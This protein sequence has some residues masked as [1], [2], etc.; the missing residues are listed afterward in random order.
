MKNLNV[1]EC[2]ANV[3]QIR[4]AYREEHPL[5]HDDDVSAERGSALFDDRQSLVN[6]FTTSD[7][8]L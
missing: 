3:D 5:D 7:I 2:G 6:F 1:L 4:A 8:V